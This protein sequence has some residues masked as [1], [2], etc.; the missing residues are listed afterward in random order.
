MGVFQ[1]EFPLMKSMPLIDK[2]RREC[3]FYQ[4]DKYLNVDFAVTF[5]RKDNPCGRRGGGGGGVDGGEA[6]SL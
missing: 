3:G 5:L 4:V 2:D 6:E 1:W